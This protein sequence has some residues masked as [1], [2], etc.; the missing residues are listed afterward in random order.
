[1]QMKMPIL[2]ALSA[3]A[4]CCWFAGSGASTKTTGLRTNQLVSPANVDA[5][6]RFSWKMESDRTGAAQ[7]A[8]R[9][10]VFEGVRNPREVWDSGDVASSESV[11]IA[12]AGAPLKDAHKY[13]WQVSVKDEK[14]VW[15]A[16]AKGFFETGLFTTDLWAGSQWISAADAREATE[17]ERTKRQV[18]AA[19]TS[20]FVKEVPNGKAVTEA[21][22]TVAGLGVFEAYVNGEPVSRKGCRAAGGALVRDALKPGFTHVKKTRYSFTYDVTHLVKTGA[23]DSNVFAAQVSAGWWRDK[24]VNYAGKKSAFRAVLILRHADGTETRWP[25][26]L[27]WQTAV[28]G[29]VVRA[30]I[31]D[32]EFYDARVKTC[33]MKKGP[34]AAF[35]PAVANAEFTGEILPMVG[36]TIRHRDDL[37]LAPVA[38]WVWRGVD[39]LEKDAAGKVVKYG[40]VKK[41][42]TYAPD[43]TMR[44]AAGETLVLDFAQ[45]A[46]AVPCFLARAAAGTELLIK[47][48]EILN[49]G[50][51]AVSRN[52][53]G[54][55]GSVYRTNLRHLRD[56]GAMASYVFAGE[57]L[58]RYRPQ[59]TF[60]GY[61][62]MS[63]TATGDVTIEKIC[64][65]PVTSTPKWNE[66]ATLATGEKDVNRLIQNVVWGQRSN[67]LSVSTDCPQRNERLGWTADTQVFVKTASYNANVYGFHCKWMR[68][69]RDSVDRNGSFPGV[70][71]SAQYGN[72]CERLGWSDAGVIVPY[73][74]WTQFGDRAIVDQNWAAM[75]RFVDYLATSP[76]TSGAAQGYQWNDWLSYEKLE[77]WYGRAFEK[78][79]DGRNRPKPDAQTYWRY[80]GGCYWLWDARMM[81][82]MARGTGRTEEAAHYGK[83]AANA[84]AYMRR[85]FIDPK[86]G[87]L[88]PLFRDMQTPALFAIKL[89]LFADAKALDAAKKA[90]VQNFH[91][92]GDCLQTG[93]LGTSILMDTL[94]YDVGAPELA[95]TVLLQ[96]KN[97]S[98][99]YSVDQGATTIWERWDSYRKDIGIGKAG[100][101]SF[102]HYAYGAVQA[103]MFGTM[104]GIR[105][106]VRRPGFRHVLL[107]PIPDKRLG[108][109]EADYDS[110]HGRIASAWRYAADGTWTWT[111]TIPA[112]VTATVT[113][114]GEK[115]VEYVSGT[116]TVTRTLK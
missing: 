74:L 25:T 114:P 111:F 67:Y 107:A 63:L 41:L 75:R 6:P 7:T 35:K 80:L 110:A 58:E 66:T 69:M 105:E 13:V 88:I 109:V 97:P 14:G 104:A 40:T 31:F 21:W 57:G 42:R 20:C 19:G 27:S 24:I 90:L 52:N 76:Y 102:N 39:G 23:A 98:W 55:E 108:H 9:V 73:T 12:Y 82:E 64:S 112:N 65:I 53:D 113:V 15:L 101:N 51:G 2:A 61:R 92:H 3:L 71:P 87:L 60:F 93:F 44:L 115:P 99:L 29:P 22:W 106:D 96:H 84:L 72:E 16:P 34:C 70:A 95:Y 28:T 85:N 1:M 10:R 4:G 91:D 100:M 86:D 45:N 17:E 38:A 50:A 49:D 59:F 26:D 36:P 18:A 8:Y 94:T 62:F 47:P 103:W 68:D 79:P 43:A 81:A 5:R 32:G 30:G 37:A 54:P 33:W 56:H 116:Y 77:S 89:G 83:M 11:G 78:G 46:A 48:A